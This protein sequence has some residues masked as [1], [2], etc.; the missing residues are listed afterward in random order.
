MKIAILD[1]DSLFLEKFNV[2]VNKYITEYFQQ[3]DIDIFKNHFNYVLHNKYDLIFIDIDLKDINGIKLAAKIKKTNMNTIIIFVS[4]KNNLVFD[5]LSV[6]PFHFIRKQ[7][8][9]EDFML[10]LSLLKKYYTKNNC[11]ITLEF[12][13]RQTQI[14]INDIIYIESE[15]H[16]I[17]ILTIN[18]Y[19]KYRSSLKNILRMINNDFFVQIQKSII[20]NLN[21]VIEMDN[22][23]IFYLKNGSNFTIN[24]YYKKV[25]LQK[26]K[27]YLLS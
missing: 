5:A 11:I 1:D 19:Y 22:N 6:Q 17:N 2:L 8:L 9:M 24:R 14:N 16:L 12:H 10:V 15:G 18:N 3:C 21:Y 25:V 26:Y 13:G 27:E 20:I 23:Y 7:N 4:S